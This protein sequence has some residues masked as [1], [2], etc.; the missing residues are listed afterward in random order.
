MKKAWGI[1]LG[2]AALVTVFV[3]VLGA[4]AWR[5]E[6][7]LLTQNIKCIVLAKT[8]R[9]LVVQSAER[10]NTELRTVRI[11]KTA[12]SG[13]SI[14]ISETVQVGDLVQ[15]ETE[16]HSDNTETLLT[17]QVISASAVTPQQAAEILEGTQPQAVGNEVQPANEPDAQDTSAAQS[18]SVTS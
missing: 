6:E 14:A 2:T 18:Q 5:N 12:R 9:E 4:G 11:G 15:M 1:A 13:E 3:C 8:N 10:A 17:V 7:P 16:L